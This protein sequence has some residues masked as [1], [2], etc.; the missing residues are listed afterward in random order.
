MVDRPLD[1]R[2]ADS[3]PIP[4]LFDQVPGVYAFCREHLF[5][6]DTERI[7]TALW[8]SG[9]PARGAILL[10]L[11][12]GPGFYARRLAGLF[13]DLRVIGLDRSAAQLE[14][15][16]ARLDEARIGTCRFD[17]GDATALPYPDASVDAVI[18]A[19]L[20]A[21]VEDPARVVAEA[22]RVLRP[23]GRCFVAEP[24]SSIRAAVPIAVMRLAAQVE[25]ARRG[26]LSTDCDHVEVLD[27]VSFTVL[28]RTPRWRR[29]LEWVDG[30][31]QYALLEKGGVDR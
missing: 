17:L 19:R 26:R 8:P 13:P 18:S 22:Y 31:Y 20:L 24:R 1:A 23:G 12:C 29:V 10:E 25:A 14:R 16:R 28:V 5:R 4:S 2:I 6:D 30:S 15:A 7:A 27:R 3:G 9:A 11:G 21:A